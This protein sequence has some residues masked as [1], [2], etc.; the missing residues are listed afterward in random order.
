MVQRAMSCWCYR[1]DPFVPTPRGRHVLAYDV[2][3]Y[4]LSSSE[5]YL[6]HWFSVM[7]LASSSDLVAPLRPPPHSPYTAAFVYWSITC[8]GSGRFCYLLRLSRAWQ[9]NHFTTSDFYSHNL[10]FMSLLHTNFF[11][12]LIFIL[13]IWLSCL[14]YIQNYGVAIMWMTLFFLLEGPHGPP[15]SL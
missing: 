11:L 9:I 3:S 14:C 7:L 13:T 6:C 4:L 10:T 15:I 2:A 1:L 8:W 12:L 5:S